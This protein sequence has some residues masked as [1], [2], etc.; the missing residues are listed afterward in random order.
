LVLVI[1]GALAYAN[2]PLA[3]LILRILAVAG[4]AAAAVY[5]AYRGRT[6]NA[7]ARRL[8]PA[9]T[10]FALVTVAAACN[11]L[12]FFGINLVASGAIAGFSAGGALLVA[13]ATAVPLEPAAARPRETGTG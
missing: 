8:A 1:L 3:G 10:T 9:A 6:G 2:M 12:G 11:A 7:G 13:M 5:F 4:A